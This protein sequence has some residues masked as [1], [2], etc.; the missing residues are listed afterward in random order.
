MVHL[1][2]KTNPPTTLY[3]HKVHVKC[4]ITLLL[5]VFHF[6]IAKA[7]NTI[8][9][10]IVRDSIGKPLEAVVVA[11]KGTMSS[12]L[13][14]SSGGYSLEVPEGTLILSFYV[15]GTDPVEEI[16]TIVKGQILTVNK[17]LKANSIL[18]NTVDIKAKREREGMIERIDARATTIIPNASG[19][20]VE[21]TIKTLPFVSSNNEL[22][23]TYSVRGGNY[24]ENLVYVNG[25]EIY[26]PFLVRSGQQ[27]GLSF[28]NS[29]LVS[30]IAFSAGGFSASYGDK[31][32]SVLDIKYKKPD[33]F[34]GSVY[35]S[36]LGAGF[37]LEGVTKK[38]KTNYLLGFRQKSNQ[39]VLKNLDTKGEYKPS[40]TDVQGLVNFSLSR[41]TELSVLGNYSRNRYEVIPTDRETEFG[42]I[43]E[44][45]KFT[46]F[47]EG[48]EVD[49]Y[50]ATQGAISLRHQVDS[51]LQIRFTTGAFYTK[52]QEYFDIIGAYSLDELEK[53]FGSGDFGEV[54]FNRGVGAFL[55]HARNDL[56]ALVYYGEH[57]GLYLLNNSVIT[58]GVKAQHEDISDQLDEWVYRDSSD[59]A[60]PHPGDNPGDTLII[61]QQ[62]VVND[63]VKSES[64]LISNR[65]SG[66]LQFNHEFEEVTLSAGVR[67]THWDYNNETNIS[68]RVSLEWKPGWNKHLA[69]RAAT[70]FYYQP[71]FYR[72]LRNLQ[73]VLNTEI[74]S[75]RSIHFIG[76]MDYQF[77][78]WG[79]EFKLSAEAYYKQLDNVIPYK[80]D[81]LRLRYLANNDA[82][83]YAYGAGM[84]LNGEFVNGIESWLSVSYLK[85]EE[86][87]K[88]DYIYS[89]YNAEGEQ[90]TSNVP[91]QDTAY[92]TK[93]AVGYI[94]RPADQRVTVSLFFQD[95]LPK[96]PS[97][98]MHLTVLFGSGLP[99]GPPGPDRYKD[100][101]R[102]PT[103]RRVD[104][105]FTKII[106]DEDKENKSRLPLV[107]K[108]NSLWFSLEVFN[109]LQVNNTVA[110][111]WITDVTGRQYAV[112]NY[113]SSRLINAKLTA[114]F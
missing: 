41:K 9:R 23:S 14:N 57:R 96:F 81:N 102:M 51:N 10:G 63:L 54:A 67:F 59:Y 80:S 90:I 4:L 13:T 110:Y 89:S 50:A 35:A 60:V 16:I 61:D 45:L 85:T 76:G 21:A 48:K 18:M 15:F 3:M 32:S 68:P 36:L 64:D 77:L 108:M 52:E 104:I 12:T 70:G 92:S 11:I 113:L 43:N 17:A 20:G 29:D 75:Q 87:I 112:P 28:I 107:K 114:R 56:E 24:D 100:I 73:G 44:A 19:N 58:W 47:F 106:I 62:V 37:H 79:R 53:D 30:S 91:L 42:N 83:G 55:N 38:K 27:E 22:S 72:E 74:K 103:Y 1:R 88:N 98:R 2:K 25:I 65:M 93:T 26:R 82:K 94:P 34:S 49:R 109:L 46:V 71:P 31:L 39:F 69:F 111:S 99:F 66:F 6:S 7:Q 33:K 101:I 78:A 97:Y 86:D 95:Y 84:R 105:G 5:M 40:F 8:V